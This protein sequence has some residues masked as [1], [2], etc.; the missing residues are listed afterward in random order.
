MK[1]NNMMR[2]AS[3][4]LVAVL[5]STCVISGT[6]AKYTSAIKAEDSAIVA[7]FA[8]KAF[9]E[10]AV[11]NDTATVEIFN[12]VYDTKGVD[13][14][15]TATGVD[16]VEV[17][18]AAD[19]AAPIVAPGTW[20]KFSYTLENESDVVVTYA[21]DYTI[22]EAGIPLL[23]SI[24]GTNWTDTLADV[25]ATQIAIDGDDVTITIYWQWAYEQTDV[26]T[27][28]ATDTSLGHTGTAAPS[29]TIDVTFT[30]VD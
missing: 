24:D 30:Q 28:D 15:A 23:W 10:D 21:V 14:F 17:R 19:D 2:I 27:G 22:E 29:I 6:F 11:A 4:L 16:D 18:N 5:L 13:N 7:K 26:A 9:G 25:S 12:T 8:V 1:K 20:G 3:V